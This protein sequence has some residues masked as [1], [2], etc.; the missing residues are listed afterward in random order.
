MMEGDSF[1][2]VIAVNNTSPDWSRYGHII[3]DIKIVLQGLR[4]WQISDPKVVRL[5]NHHDLLRQTPPPVSAKGH[6]PEPRSG[7]FVSFD[8][9]T[10]NLF[11]HLVYFTIF[12]VML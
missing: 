12:F 10:G 2:V 9:V 7:L 8:C 6:R 4:N 1:Q 11:S 3:E 5:N